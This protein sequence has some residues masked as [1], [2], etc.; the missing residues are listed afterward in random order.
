MIYVFGGE[1]KGKHH[2][3]IKISV[4]DRTNKLITE[5]PWDDPAINEAF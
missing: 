5:K 2:G 1:S 4:R 3:I